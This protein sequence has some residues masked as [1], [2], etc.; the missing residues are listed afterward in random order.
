MWKINV[1][2]K[3]RACGIF[4]QKNLVSQECVAR[5]IC[6][7]CTRRIRWSCEG[8]TSVTQQIHWMRL[9]H[10]LLRHMYNLS[11]PNLCATLLVS[12]LCL[13]V[14]W[15][16]LCYKMSVST[17][18]CAVP[19]IATCVDV[20]GRYFRDHSNALALYKELGYL[21][22]IQTDQLNFL[23]HTTPDFTPDSQQI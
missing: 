22:S 12:L 7:V 14:Y 19:Y 6:T 17:L 20:S 1:P 4:G 23:F 3:G 16:L 21:N 15:R 9:K 10:L 5:F 18:Y 13:R 11:L 2:R 8:L